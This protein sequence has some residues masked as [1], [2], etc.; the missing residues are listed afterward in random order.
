MS[1]EQII[2]QAINAERLGSALGP[3]KYRV[4]KVGEFVVSKELLSE[5][6]ESFP[7]PIQGIEDRGKYW[8]V[9]A[10]GKRRTAL[11]TTY[12]IS[13]GLPATP[14]QYEKHSVVVPKR[15]IPSAFLYVRSTPKY[16]G[17]AVIGLKD[18]LSTIAKIFCMEEVGRGYYMTVPTEVANE[19]ID[20]IVEALKRAGFKT[21]KVGGSDYEL[22]AHVG[23]KITWKLRKSGD[24]AERFWIDET[25]FNDVLKSSPYIRA[26]N[27]YVLG[28]K[29]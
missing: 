19:V 27:K 24:K 2:P 7:Y 26:R 17:I 25:A 6:I 11:L 10:G 20:K 23:R 13:K 3:S 16:T 15:F 22:L 1:V 18:V 4:P 5:L 12:L 14:S 9:R 28:V 29:E 21:V 8:L